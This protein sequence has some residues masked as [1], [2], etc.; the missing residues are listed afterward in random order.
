MNNKKFLSIPIKGMHC[1]SCEILVE[2][3]LKEVENV[4]SVEVSYKTGE[5]KIFYDNEA[6]ND[7]EIIKI[8]NKSGYDIGRGGKSPFINKNRRDYEYLGLALLILTVIYLTLK[9]LGIGDISLDTQSSNLSSG[10]IILIGLVAGFSTCMALVGGLVL[11]LSTKYALSRPQATA[12]QKF[13]PHLFFGLGR[14]VSYAVLGGFLGVIGSAFKI[15]S[16]LNGVLIILVALI[17]FVMGLQLVNIFPRLSNFKIVL[18][19]RV[20]R[21]FGF[22]NSDDYSNKGAA[23]LG[24]LTFFLPCGFT[25][26]VQLYAISTG[27]FLSG[28]MVMGLFALGTAPGLLSIGGITSIVKGEIKEIFFKVAGLAV[29]IFSLFNLSSGYTLT[30]LDFNKKV[31]LENKITTDPNVVFKDGVQVVYM[32]ETNR[33]YSPNSFTIKKGIPVRWVIDA[34]APYSCASALIVPKYKIRTF[35]KAGENIVEFTPT[36]VGVVSFSCS[37]GMYT[38]RFN[39][40]E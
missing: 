33:G 10:F 2:D 20:V 39:V 35:L 36:N 3:N 31:N 40:V 26:A 38:G 21:F 19:K 23:I 34:E 6:P 5:A 12:S 28:A 18:P 17:M 11:G 25:Q 4:S 29:I 24:A 32:K 27:S 14:I 9:L 13:K 30:S 16:M 37:M 7:S 15:S 8:I 1:R 22:G